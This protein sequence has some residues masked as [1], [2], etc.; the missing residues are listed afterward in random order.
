MFEGVDNIGLLGTLWQIATPW[1]WTKTGI[2]HG[3]AITE[4]RKIG[5]EI[6]DMRDT[7]GNN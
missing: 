4:L 7:N 6:I 3:N 5:R 1:N 2:D